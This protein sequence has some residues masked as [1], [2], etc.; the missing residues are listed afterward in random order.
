MADAIMINGGM[1]L[2]EG[3]GVVDLGTL[4]WA[5][6]SRYGGLMNATINDGYYSSSSDNTESLCAGYNKYGDWYPRENKRYTVGSNFYSS[7]SCV[8]TIR[9]DD[10]SDAE[11]FRQAVSGVM[12]FYK[13]AV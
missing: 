8:L 7:S 13:K 9:D 1:T 11:L 6:D 3:I 10:Y 12:F 4:N 2:P 5:Y